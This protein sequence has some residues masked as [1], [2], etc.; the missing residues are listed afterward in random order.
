MRSEVQILPDPP[1]TWIIRKAI[2]G[3][4]SVG[5]A[6][7]LQA[8]G[9]RF[10]PDWLH[11]PWALFA[12]AR[13]V[14]SVREA[15]HTSSAVYLWLYVARVFTT[16]VTVFFKNSEV[17]LTH[18]IQRNLDWNHVLKKMWNQSSLNHVAFE[19]QQRITPGSLGLYG[20]VN[21]RMWWMP[22][23]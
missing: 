12:R 17:V 11:Q 21:K 14:S 8:G 1:V 13:D 9:R 10:D 16:P 5:R 15:T 18:Q 22:R 19:N 2:R 4:S 23:R 6:P 3:H 20:Q 7:A